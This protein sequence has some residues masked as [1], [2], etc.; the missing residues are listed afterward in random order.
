MSF[1][2]EGGSF[3]YVCLVIRQRW[4]LWRKAEIPLQGVCAG[5]S[6]GMLVVSIPSGL[7]DWWHAGGVYSKCPGCTVAGSGLLY[8]SARLTKLDTGIGGLALM[9]TGQDSLRSKTCT[10]L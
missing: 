10:I 2:E 3:D 9:R 5:D 7:G 8:C 4:Q 1:D 6:G